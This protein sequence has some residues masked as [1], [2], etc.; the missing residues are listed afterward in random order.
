[1]HH[2]IDPRTG[3]PTD[4]PWRTVSVAA[5]SAVEANA[6]STAAIVLGDRAPA[7]LERQ[8]VAARLI[9]R[10]GRVT[11]LGGWPTERT[12][13]AGSVVPRASAGAR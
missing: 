12:T 2:I 5:E 6:C 7:W 1:M 11:T 9:D 13:D 8:G 3:R 4:G 10:D